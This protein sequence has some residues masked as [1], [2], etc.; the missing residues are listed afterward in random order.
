MVV[1]VVV[2]RM[3]EG[4]EPL[5]EPQRGEAED[6]EQDEETRPDDAERM[7]KIMPPVEGLDGPEQPSSDDEPE[8]R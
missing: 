5:H 3:S 2:R 6:H 1:S 8:D 4:L 7:R